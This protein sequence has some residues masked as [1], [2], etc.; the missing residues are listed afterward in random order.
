MRKLFTE[1]QKAILAALICYGFWGISF[2]ASR[3]AL[4]TVS[5]FHLLSHRFLLAFVLMTILCFTPLGGFRLRGR[6]LLPLLMLGIFQPVAYFIGEQYGILHSGTI[7]SGVMIALIPIVSTLAAIPILHEKISAFQ[8][9]CSLLSVGGVIGVG[10]M[11]NSGGSLDWIGVAGL[12]AAVFSAAAY[13]ILGRSISD[14]YTPFE[15][16]YAMI[17][18]GAAAFSIPVVISLHGDAS[19]YFEPFAD[20]G[21]LAAVLFLGVCCSVISFFLSSYTLTRLPVAKSAVFNNLTTAISVVAGA[22]IL[23][24]PFSFMGLIYCTMILLGIYGVL[25]ADGRSR[26]V[27]EE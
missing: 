22:V 12:V 5:V 8:F 3:V 18:I 7:F 27:Q 19:A 16:T 13:L 11:T 14:R 1:K 9:F 17:S 21:Y 25:N 15:R 2:M 6:P 26:R 10:L 23:H 24:E 4:N 20:M